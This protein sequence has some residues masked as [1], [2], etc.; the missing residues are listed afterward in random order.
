VSRT[1]LNEPQVKDLIKATAIKRSERRAA[2]E[3]KKLLKNEK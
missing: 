3:I 2:N 1:A